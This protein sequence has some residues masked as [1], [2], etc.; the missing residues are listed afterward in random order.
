M[1]LISI[2][3]EQRDLVHYLADDRK[4]VSEHAKRF[5]ARLSAICEEG[6]VK[7][8]WETTLSIHEDGTTVDLQTP[9][10]VARAQLSLRVDDNV[11]GLWGIR[12]H[13]VNASGEPVFTRVTALR[14]S[15]EGYIFL[16]EGDQ[17]PISARAQLVGGED[18]TAYQVMGSI[19]Y[20]L[21]SQ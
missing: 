1:E 2:T 8:R 14:I 18:G 10:G 9:F 21:G 13:T 17:K 15:K 6:S 12:R 4:R 7:E 11:Y 16:G 19:L 3:S 5:I 20:L